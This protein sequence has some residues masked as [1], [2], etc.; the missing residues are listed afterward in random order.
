MANHASGNETL[1]LYDTDKDGNAVLFLRDGKSV[2]PGNEITITY[3]DEKGACEM[4]FSYGFLEDTMT[5]AKELYLDLDIPNDDPLRIA[6]KHVSKSPPGFRL[7]DQGESIGW[8]GPFVW[9]LCVNQEDGL[10]FKILQSMDGERDLKVFWD[11]SEMS[12]V[13]KLQS[14]LQSDSK[15]DVFQLRAAV[16]LRD[17]I[18]QQLSALDDSKSSLPEMLPIAEQQSIMCHYAIKL[19]Q[20]ERALMLQAHEMFESKVSYATIKESISA[21]S[22]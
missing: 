1:A 6:K 8:E 10:E 2:G 16:I 14:L 20:L 17:R 13:S 19:R 4:L 21:S 5:S 7:F 11:N 22:C 12:D 18:A 9:L 15:W 3:G